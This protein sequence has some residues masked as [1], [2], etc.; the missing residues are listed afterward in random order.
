MR[1]TVA[2]SLLLGMLAACGDDSPPPPPPFDAGR[3]ADTMT[4]DAGPEGDGGAYASD[5]AI[6]PDGAPPDVF[7]AGF[8][9]TFPDSGPPEPLLICPPGRPASTCRANCADDGFFCTD[10]FCEGM[11]CVPGSLCNADEQ[12]GS[13]NCIKVEGAEPGDRG[14]CAPTE[15]PCTSIH[16]CAHGFRCEEG[17]CIDRRIPCG[18]R[19]TACPRNHTCTFAPV[20]GR[21]FCVPAHAPC[22]SAG[23]CED[24]ASCAD[25]DGDTETECLLLGTCTSN[26][27]CGEGTS[28]GVDPGTSQAS[29]EADG[30]CRAGACPAGRTCLDTGSGTARCVMDGGSCT[31]DSE[32]PAQAICGA[33]LPNDPLRCLTFDEE[34]E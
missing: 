13:G 5:S 3:R 23:Q 26:A 33:V 31:R 30:P 2:L 7:D 4:E 21:L 15:G 16:D 28:C 32:C 22:E 27:D 6:A 10:A 9:A 29:C 11:E 34:A 14:L 19:D 12:C 24:G 20:D 25:V 1:V 8:D 17:A 18:F